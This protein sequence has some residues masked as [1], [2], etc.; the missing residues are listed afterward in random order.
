MRLKV[1]LPTR[2]LMDEKVQKVTAEAPNGQF[3]LKPRHVDFASVLV[4][5]L[6]SWETEDGQERFAAVDRGT[7]VKCG[8]QVSV[9]AAGAVRGPDLGSLKAAVQEQFQREDERE[10]TVRTAMAKIEAGFVRRFVEI[11]GRRGGG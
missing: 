9:S 4:P 7:L 11:H 1:L 5:G 2:V 8:D 3:C 6:L 10:K